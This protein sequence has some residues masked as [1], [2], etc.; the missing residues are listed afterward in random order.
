MKSFV[1]MTF[2]QLMH[3]TAMTLELKEKTNLFF[4]SNYLGVDE[5]FLDRVRD[6]G[7]FNSVVRLDQEENMGPYHAAMEKTE[8]MSPKEIDKIGNSIFEKYLEP[9]YSK[10]FANA[11]FNDDIYV[12]NDFQRPYYFISK[13]F[14][15]I[16][17][18]EDG[19]GSLSQQMK[20]H[21]FKGRYAWVVPFLGKYYPEPLYKNPKITKIISSRTF[22]DLPEYYQKKLE[23]L[24][25]K[26]LMEKNKDDFIKAQLKIFNLENIEIKDGGILILSTP[27][28]RGKF[29]D[30]IDNFIL[31]KKL[32]EEEKA[33]GRKIFIKPHPADVAVDYKLY[34]DEQVTVLPRQFPIELLEYQGVKFSKSISFG[35]TAIVDNLCDE[36]VIMY[37]GNNKPDDIKAFI[38]DY[39]QNEFITLNVYVM[40]TDKLSEQCLNVRMP[41]GIERIK[42]NVTFIASEDK[43]ENYSKAHNFKFVDNMEELEIYKN[44]ISK[45]EFDYFIL[46]DGR[47]FGT[48]FM[49]YLCSVPEKKVQFCTTFFNYT[50]DGKYDDS[51]RVLL[52]SG[53]VSEAFSSQLRNRLWHRSISKYV[54][55]ECQDSIGEALFER[56]DSV[57]HR[58]KLLLYVDNRQYFKIDDGDSYF[59]E[60]LKELQEEDK[61]E[62]A[63][64]RG[65]AL[66]MKEYYDW[67][68]I[69]SPRS[70]KGLLK[71]YLEDSTL[72]DSIKA[73]A[74]S[75]MLEQ[76]LKEQQS[77]F[78]RGIYSRLENA[79]DNNGSNIKEIGKR[80]KRKIKTVKTNK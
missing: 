12:Y 59:R 20:V 69:M 75:E 10:K 8:G 42:L 1:V 62:S 63:I 68:T 47:N 80:I 58:A 9:Y 71:K 70:V 35:S 28:S 67:A 46:I 74:E 60:K 65:T 39:V 51:R 52:G 3:A 48:A 43:K 14:K 26:D 34:E 17:G 61:E 55:I 2:Y 45:D 38:Q 36:S 40:L 4:I 24:D 78:N 16:I 79:G 54:D 31:Y 33:N 66:L 5:V 53:Q 11:D 27:L 56:R 7:L 18:V 6:T 41:K 72:S 44:V 77:E 21:H 32:I 13:H 23:V 57:I 73:K 64:A 49:E 30:S 50:Y 76:L 29:C 37:Q 22:G 25:F 19:Y 15:T